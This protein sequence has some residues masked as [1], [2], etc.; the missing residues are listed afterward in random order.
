MAAEKSW[1]VFRY[2]DH[3]MTEQER[4]AYRHLVGTA[5]ATH[6]HICASCYLVT[7]RFCV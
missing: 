6:G 5:K 4:F 7:P 2:F 3:L 1:Y